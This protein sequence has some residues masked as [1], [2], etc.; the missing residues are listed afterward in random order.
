MIQRPPRYTR[1]DTLFPYTTLFR[2][3][4]VLGMTGNIPAK[5]ADF[6]GPSTMVIPFSPGGSTDIIGRL[7]AD[8]LSTAVKQP[9]VVE[10][11]A[12]AGGNIGASMVAK[13][14]PDGRTVLFGTTGILSM[15]EYLYSR[16]GYKDRKSTR[17][18][19]S[20]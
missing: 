17:L 20:H 9:V 8:R 6:D 13:A 18:N 11:R 10:N 19:S 14:K 4:G 7:L 3:I 16:P 5:A 12:G 15:N 1:T 2:S